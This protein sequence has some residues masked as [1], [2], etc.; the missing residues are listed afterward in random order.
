M[1]LNKNGNEMIG[2]KLEDFELL[3]L[4]GEGAYGMVLKVRSLLNQKIY[5]MKIINL[6]NNEDYKEYFDSEIEMLK[7][8]N[9]QNI[10]KYYTNFETKKK[11]YI[12]MEYLEYGALSDYI[13]LLIHL[14]EQDNSI[15]T[16]KKGEIIHIFLQCINALKYLKDLKIIHRDIKPEN[17]FI[18]K[19]EGIKIGDFGVAAVLKDK[20]K[21]TII[22]SK[23]KKNEYTVV[24]TEDFMSPEV[25]KGKQY[26]EKAD[27]YSMGL[28][29]YKIYFL[30]DYREKEWKIKDNKIKFTFVRE[31]KP[32]QIKDPLIDFIFS[33]IEE[34]SIKR[35]DVDL[36]YQQINKIYYNYFISNNISNF[37]SVIRCL[38]HFSYLK[39]F[40]LKKYKPENKKYSDNFY[41]C[42]INQDNWDEA[43]IFF[44]QKFYEDNGY[45]FFEFNKKI[46]PYFILNFILEKMQME[47]YKD[48]NKKEKITI[49]KNKYDQNLT[50]NFKKIFSYN[51]KTIIGKNFFSVM[52][53]YYQCMNC[54]NIFNNYSSSFSLSFDLETFLRNHKNQSDDI[55]ILDLFKY[56]NDITLLPQNYFKFYCLNCKKESMHKEKKTFFF[57]PLCLVINF[58]YNKENNINKINIPEKLDFS[59]IQKGLSKESAKKYYLI[60]IIKNIDGHYISIIN[61][62]DKGHKYY[63]Y[64]NNKISILQSYKDHD[65]G[66]VEMLFYCFSE[67]K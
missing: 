24:G 26:N 9:H 66:R 33:M 21:D 52:T 12:I 36:L 18:S 19:K 10:V 25:M 45:N 43:L 6:E 60:G 22:N 46:E 32:E 27:I 38:G 57:L 40:F 64:D 5:A 1:S 13:N 50:E 31:S 49:S 20:N 4:L 3:T 29:F 17:I 58:I 37:Y 39:D 30:K 61:G 53:L 48:V 11:I 55:N 7:K 56:Q 28:I 14:Y 54:K 62:N 47:F 16:I 8:L 65:I 41:K 15:I 51:F 63:L 59:S 2:N 35:P 34:D 42:I 23:L 67:K 44:K